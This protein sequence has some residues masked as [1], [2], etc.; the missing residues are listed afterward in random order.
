MNR[1][2]DGSRFEPVIGK[3]GDGSSPSCAVIDE[4]HEHKDDT[5]YDTMETGMG[6]RNQPIMLVITTAGATI[7]GACIF[8]IK[9]LKKC[10]M[11][12]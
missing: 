5:L 8:C 7:G 11:V 3:P 1:V 12:C 10:L 2:A 9:M 6:A 4:Y